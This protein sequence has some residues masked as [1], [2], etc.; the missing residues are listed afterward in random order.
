MTSAG[1]KFSPRVFTVEDVDSEQTL[2]R[3]ELYLEA[4]HKA[5]RLYRRVNPT[6]GS[7]VDLTTRIKRILSSW[8][9]V[10]TWWTSTSH[11]PKK[12]PKKKQNVALNCLNY[13]FS[14]AYYISWFRS[15]QVIEIPLFCKIKKTLSQLNNPNP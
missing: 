10:T 15:G 14:Y 6:T 7:K 4:M 13:H 2:K 12:L 5:F 9:E 8:R 1:F 3:F 11:F